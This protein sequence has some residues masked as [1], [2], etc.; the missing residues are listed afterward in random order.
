MFR[1]IIMVDRLVIRCG[2]NLRNACLKL[3]CRAVFFFGTCAVFL[4]GI[5]LI[6]IK[7][8]LKIFVY[9]GNLYKFAEM[10]DYLR[11]DSFYSWLLLFSI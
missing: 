2:L 6:L 9:I 4:C 1:T 7:F 3:L 5:S 10:K 8:F 11:C